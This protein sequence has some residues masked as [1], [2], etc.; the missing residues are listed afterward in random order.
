MKLGVG[1][2]NTQFRG[3]HPYDTRFWVLEHPKNI[4][5]TSAPEMGGTVRVSA[6]R[7]DGRLCLR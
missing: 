5:G 2:G 1:A 7:D 4:S 3:R 6:L